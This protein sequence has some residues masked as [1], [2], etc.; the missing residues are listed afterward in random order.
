VEL[1]QYD[2]ASSSALE[3]MAVTDGIVVLPA[4]WT[5]IVPGA[6]MGAVRSA[7]VTRNTFRVMRP[8]PLNVQV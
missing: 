6:S 3:E 2:T 8:D 1:F 4:P 5:A 7:P